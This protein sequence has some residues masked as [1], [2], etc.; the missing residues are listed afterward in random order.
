MG[1]IAHVIFNKSGVN[2]AG[3]SS[4]SNRPSVQGR[5]WT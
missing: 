5:T 1:E 4:A 3:L 2:D